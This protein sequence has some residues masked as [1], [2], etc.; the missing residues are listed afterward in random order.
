LIFVCVCNISN[1]MYI[2]I[3][4]LFNVIKYKK[5]QIES[6]DFDKYNGLPIEY[7]LKEVINFDDIQ[8]HKIAAEKKKN[9]NPQLSQT[10]P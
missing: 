8:T 10:K 1:N 5:V 4:A 3:Y 9:S 7:I 6:V 2:N